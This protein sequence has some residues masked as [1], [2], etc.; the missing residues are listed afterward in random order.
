VPAI[1]PLRDVNIGQ[2]AA[3]QQQQSFWGIN[4]I[5]QQKRD[6]LQYTPVPSSTG[7][8]PSGYASSPL[9]DGSQVLSYSSGTNSKGTKKTDPFAG[10]INQAPPAQTT[11]LYGTWVQGLG[12]WERDK[13]LNAGDLGHYNNT[14]TV[15]GG[16]D[17]TFLGV[18]SADD[19]FVIGLVGSETSS[20]VDYF[21]TPT[22]L[23][24]VGPGVGVY[25]EYVKGGFSGDLTA[26]F[27]FLQLTEDFEG[28]TPNVGINVLNSGL[29]GNVQYKFSAAGNS[30]FEPTMG[31]TLTHTSFGSGAVALALEDAYTVRLQ[32]GGRVGTTW[33]LGRGITVDGNVKLVAYGN[34]IAQGTAASGPIGGVI[35]PIAPT[36][37]G[38]IL[39]EVDPELCFNLPNDY[40]LTLSGQARFGNAL[41]GGSA[42]VNLR[43]QW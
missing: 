37:A 17:R 9:T 30:F 35:L 26:K 39:G 8:G 16:I 31:F 22:A 34:A 20:H 27:D 36:D 40:S 19:A 25:S 7:S 5:L 10:I 12:D 23:R 3:S 21:N 33:D 32:A 43:K 11:P 4:Q 2:I 24:L 6:H 29:S 18:L 41:A 13:A 15:Q 14:Y 1:C 38:L 28:V 42:G